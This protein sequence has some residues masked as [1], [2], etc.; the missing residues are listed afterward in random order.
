[1]VFSDN[2]KV[3]IFS[4][5]RIRR[6]FFDYSAEGEQYYAKAY[7]TY[8]SPRDFLSL[9]TY[10][11]DQFVQEKA[12]P[13]DFERLCAERQEIFLRV[14]IHTGE[15]VGH[16]GRHRM[17][18]LLKAG[19]DK[20]AV[21]LIPT[22][23]EN[24]YNRQLIDSLQLNGQAFFYCTPSFV[25]PGRVVVENLI[26]FNNECREKLCAEYGAKVALADRIR[27]A[28]AGLK[29]NESKSIDVVLER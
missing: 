13:L 16:E 25:A 29:Q 2:G 14:D 27:D 12:Q 17:A 18:A 22:D 20:V 5:K 10:D 3:L 24:Q 21:S 1:M 26:P 7:A 4:E 11:V 28:K 23:K 9:T 6:L 19:V 15:V 8:I